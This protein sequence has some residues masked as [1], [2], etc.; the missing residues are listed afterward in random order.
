MH[1]TSERG[2]PRRYIQQQ[3]KQFK[4]EVAEVS[5]IEHSD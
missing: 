4:L 1:Y 5:S 2:N 3:S